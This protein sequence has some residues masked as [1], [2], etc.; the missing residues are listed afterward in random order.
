MSETIHF[1]PWLRRGLALRL[2]ARD[3]GQTD[4][5][6][7][8]PVKAYVEINNRDDRAEASIALRPADHVVGIDATQILRRYP[9]PASAEAEYGYFPLVEVS[10]PDLPWVVTPLAPNEF[11]DQFGDS[12]GRLRP[13]VVLVCVDAELSDLV[14]STDGQPARLPVPADQLPDLAESFAWSHV[15]STVPPKDVAETLADQPGAIIARL[16]C[17]RRLAPKTAYRAALVAAFVRDGDL[18][19]PAWTPESGEVTLTVYD[20]WVFT[21]GE[22]S[23]FE[24]LCLRLGP[25]TD[26]D[27]QLGMMS[28][29]VT[30]LGSVD[31][32]PEAQRPIVVDYTGALWDVHVAPRVLDRAHASRFERSVTKLLNQGDARLELDLDAPD[33]VVAPPFVGAYASRQHRVPADYWL[34]DLN[35]DPNR[36]AAAGLGAEIVRIHQERFMARAWRQAGQVRET[37]RQLSAAR[38]QS[39]IGRTVKAR[40][41]RLDELERVS[42]LRAPL[43]FVRDPEGDAPRQLLAESSIPNALL[44]PAYRRLM[45]P[46][47]VVARASAKRAKGEPSLHSAMANSFGRFHDR[48]AIRFGVP[49]APAGTTFHPPRT[50][51]RRGDRLK[52]E[53]RAGTG[54]SSSPFGVAPLGGVSSVAES[55]DDVVLG[56]A[57]T[58]ELDKVAALATARVRPMDATRRRMLSRVPALGEVLAQNGVQDDEFPS[59]VLIGPVIDEALVWSLIELSPDLLMPGVQEFPNNSVRV[60]ETNAAFVASFL[61]GANHEMTRELLWREYPADLG[62]TTFQRFWDRPDLQDVDIQPMAGWRKKAE[63]DRLG[64]EGGSSVVVLVRGDLIRHYPSVRILL[65]DP[66][67]RTLMP[68]FAGWIPPD[69][70]F[71]AFD[72]PRSAT[73]KGTEWKVI[74]EEQVTEPRFGLDTTPQGEHP[75]PLNSWND[76]SWEHLTGQTPGGHMT[77]LGGGID[78]RYLPAPAG[79]TWGLNAAHMARITYQAPFRYTMRLRDL[80][81]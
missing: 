33:P 31:P 81:G 24:E 77:V 6:R 56:S 36:R 64:A 1:L 29:D 61:A 67:G 13:W 17:P 22:A 32:W 21:T 47:A 78:R 15:Q 65:V 60:V 20:T 44:S 62:S 59:R 9:A 28:M 42:L 50:Q 27:F 39:E 54:I 74:F 72:A 69:V 80:I 76:L 38:L 63:L 35:L 5:P 41:D 23:S 25:V 45:R 58:L 14:T 51:D 75:K 26:P 71:L 34:H 52:A 19:K 43:S 8:A 68:S 79:A 16:V 2:I 37:N 11:T 48:E 57:Q 7:S 49:A 53:R 12:N 73:A 46:G 10:A 3:R 40:I 66:E 55:T 18:L 30:D 70:R 4:V